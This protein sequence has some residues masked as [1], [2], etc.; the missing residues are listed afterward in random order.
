MSRRKTEQGLRPPVVPF[1]DEHNR[2]CLRVPLDPKGSAYAVVLEHDYKAVRE[3][4][5]T[6]TWYLNANDKGQRYVRTAV[7]DGKGGTVVTTV[8]RII[9]GAG[10]RSTIFYVNKDRLD[11]RGEN[12]FWHR[13]GKAKRR[14]VELAERGAKYR[15]ERQ[16]QRGVGAQIGAAA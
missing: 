9:I 12:L 1:I 14:D 5:A 8:A 11:L 2:P 10:P 4:G 3:A 16:R 6:G 13:K 15:A 7:P